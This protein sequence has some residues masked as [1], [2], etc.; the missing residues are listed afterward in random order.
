MTLPPSLIQWRPHNRPGK[1]QF[2]RCINKPGVYSARWSVQTGCPS[3]LWLRFI[4]GTGWWG[5]QME[6]AVRINSNRLSLWPQESQNVISTPAPPF[7][8]KKKAF[9]LRKKTIHLQTSKE[10]AT[11]RWTIRRKV[12]IYLHCLMRIKLL[13]KGMF[14]YKWRANTTEYVLEKAVDH[15]AS[16]HNRFFFFPQY[17]R[18]R[19]SCGF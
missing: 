3:C 12:N 17:V 11:F 19:C 13:F 6:A 18:Q 15:N 2:P 16:T 14:L 5:A 8:L 1:T 7:F 4:R 10:K 9:F